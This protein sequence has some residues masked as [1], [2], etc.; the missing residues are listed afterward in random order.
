M[1]HVTSLNNSTNLFNDD[2][3]KTALAWKE[4]GANIIPLDGK[5]PYLQKWNELKLNAEQYTQAAQEYFV[6]NGRQCNYGILTGTHSILQDGCGLLVL[7]CDLHTDD[8]IELEKYNHARHNLVGLISPTVET[9]GGGTHTYFICALNELEHLKSTVLAKSEG[10]V[11][12][13]QDDGT[14]VETGQRLWQIETLSTGK[15]VVGAGSVH[16]VTGKTYQLVGEIHPIPQALLEACKKAS[17]GKA[18]NM[19]HAS[20]SGINLSEPPAHI[21]ENPNAPTLDVHGSVSI[22]LLREISQCVNYQNVLLYLKANGQSAIS[23]IDAWRDFV[24]LPLKSEAQ[25]RPRESEQLFSIFDETSKHFGGNYEPQSNQ[26]QWQASTEIRARTIGSF[27]DVAKFSGCTA[28]IKVSHAHTELGLR[29]RFVDK[30]RNDVRWLP[31]IGAWM[32]WGGTGW[33]IK[34]TNHAQVTELMV[35]IIKV[36][37]P[38]EAFN[39][40][41]VNESNSQAAALALNKFQKGAQQK[42][43][44]ENALALVKLDPRMVILSEQ[45]DTKPMLFRCTHHVIDLM[46]GKLAAIRR[47]DYLTKLSNVDYDPSASAPNFIKMITDICTNTETGKVDDELFN[48]LQTMC[49]LVLTGIVHKGFFIL[50]G[51]AGNNGKTTF[52]EA[53]RYMLGDYAVSMPVTALVVRVNANSADAERLSLKGARLVTVQEWP[54]QTKIDVP[55]IKGLTGGDE[56]ALRPLY[57]KQVIRFPTHAKLLIVGNHR[58]TFNESGDALWSRAHLVPFPRQFTKDEI[59]LNLSDKLQAEVAG[60]FNWALEGCKRYLA[61]RKRLESSESMKE[62]EAEYRR[63]NDRLA[64]W[65]EACTL[66]NVTNIVSQTKLYKS[67]DGYCIGQQSHPMSRNAFYAALE[68][69]G[70]AR[71]KINGER[72]FRGVEVIA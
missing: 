4:C 2:I 50:F 70:F 56:L 44:I 43:I 35:Q 63:E 33:D 19:N 52:I 68:E 59:D 26:Q 37:L 36:D 45:L 65:R 17:S 6:K 1:N 40:L 5:R 21:L 67:Y 8:P 22:D 39:M 3:Q 72:C 51:A 38:N 47:E 13:T 41:K 12:K 20:N 16:P 61:N 64:D 57:S 62:A 11:V 58:P 34:A 27:I 25:K 10:F 29:E 48:F 28:A 15:Q 23:E 24:L 9:G 55:F 7:D 14:V 32:L 60:I 53:I 66:D 31:D 54:Q 71:V 69:R 42:S 46:T 18:Q 30:Y 49:G